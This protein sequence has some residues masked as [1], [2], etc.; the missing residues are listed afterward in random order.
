MDDKERRSE[1]LVADRANKNTILPE[2]NFAIDLVEKFVTKV[3]KILRLSI[4]QFFIFEI[5]IFAN[6]TFAFCC[7]RS[8]RSPGQIARSSTKKFA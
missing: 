8:A 5:S 1:G 3:F 4:C 2:N 6:L 7:D